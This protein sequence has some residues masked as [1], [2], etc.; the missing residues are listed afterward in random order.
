MPTAKEQV[1]KLLA[2]DLKIRDI[3]KVLDISTQRVYQL[4]AE[5]RK[6]AEQAQNGSK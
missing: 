4:R 3:S 1:R 6:E 2:K 5:L